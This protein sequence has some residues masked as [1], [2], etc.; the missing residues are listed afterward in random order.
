M[1][2]TDRILIKLRRQYSESE[3]VAA[4]S[5]K[6]T[7]LEVENGKLLSEIHYLEHQEITENLN[8]MQDRYREYEHAI[9]DEDHYLDTL[10]N[11]ITTVN[12]YIEDNRNLR[13]K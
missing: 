9:D 11:Y 4:L 10:S 2:Y 3:T 8:Y 5:K 7:D 12:K 6:V 13:I 1:D